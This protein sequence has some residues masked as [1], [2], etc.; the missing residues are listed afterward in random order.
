MRIADAMVVVDE[1][2]PLCTGQ[3]HEAQRNTPRVADILLKSRVYLKDLEAAAVRCF[4]VRY[5]TN[6]NIIFLYDQSTGRARAG[7]QGGF[8]NFYVFCYEAHIYH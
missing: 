5:V 1:V 7:D 3:K 4:K 6:R 2:N 8:L